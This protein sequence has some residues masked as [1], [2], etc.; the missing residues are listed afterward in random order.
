M[1]TI[2]LIIWIVCAIYGLSFIYCKE[3]TTLMHSKKGYKRAVN[4]MVTSSVI[5]AAILIMI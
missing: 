1:K 5:L 4:L 2:F 3:R